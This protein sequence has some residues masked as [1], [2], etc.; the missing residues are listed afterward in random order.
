MSVNV[1]ELRRNLG[2]WDEYRNRDRRF[3]ERKK[4][5][6]REWGGFRYIVYGTIDLTAEPQSVTVIDITDVDAALF[7][8]RIPD[9]ADIPGLEAERDFAVVITPD[10]G[11]MAVLLENGIE[12]WVMTA[13]LPV[14][15]VPGTRDDYRR[16]REQKAGE[17]KPVLKW[18]PPTPVNLD[19]VD[20]LV[21]T[22]RGVH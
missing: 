1:N 2:A 13:E 12:T 19:T 15:V 21:P 11:H 10:E 6:V 22:I 7:Q 14:R 4:Y 16:V 9:T 17:Q 18:L 3:I 5:P 20:D 8:N